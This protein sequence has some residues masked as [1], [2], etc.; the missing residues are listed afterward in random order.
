M[1]VKSSSV[2]PGCDQ[3]LRFLGHWAMTPFV[4]EPTA[5][6]FQN[7]ETLD[8]S[9]TD[10]CDFGQPIS[11]LRALISQMELRLV[12]MIVTM[13]IVTATVY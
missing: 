9:L 6:N 5:G 8:P 1:L 4:Q 11:A 10:L 13:I 3:I 2:V 7:R 12:S